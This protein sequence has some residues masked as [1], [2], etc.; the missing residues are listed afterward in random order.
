MKCSGQNAIKTDVSLHLIA[1]TF[2]PYD[3]DLM[4]L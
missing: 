4:R 3:I 1:I 2:Y